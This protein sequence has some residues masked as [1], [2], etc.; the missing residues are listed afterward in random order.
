MSDEMMNRHSV[1]FHGVSL[2]YRIAAERGINSIKEWA[3]RWITRRMRFQDLVAL[4]DVS[5]AIP[6]GQTVGIIGHNGAGKSTLLR[7]A[8]GILRPTAGTAIVRGHQAPVIELGFGFE[9]EL[10]GRENIFFNGAL[11][12]RSQS[13]MEARLDEIV[14][15]ADLAG[16]IDQ[17]I[18]TFS[19]GMAARLAFAVAT[20]VEAQIILLDEVLAVGDASFQLKCHQRLKEFRDSGITIMLVSHDLTT[21]KSMCDDVLWLDRGSL[22]AYGPA[23]EIVPMYEASI[24][25]EPTV[26]GAI[27]T[28]TR[29][30]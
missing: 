15:F 1:E 30:E 28:T 17:P 3:I 22:R 6:V 4:S 26:G 11:L 19:T 13:E 18:R 2:R 16:F 21:V 24:G 25:E 9:A 29:S 14:E 7:V 23:A 27:E 12:G 8:A 10:S 20:T 5:F